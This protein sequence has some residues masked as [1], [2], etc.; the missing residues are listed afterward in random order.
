MHPL[1]KLVA[2][3]PQ[4]LADHAEAYAAL[5]SEELGTVSTALK[6]GVILGAAALVCLGVAAVLGGVALMLWAITPP[7]NLLAPWAL[8]ATPLAP[9]LLG[10]C[11]LAAARSAQ[12]HSTFD[13]LRGQ[14][15]ADMAMLREMAAA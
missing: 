2:T 14:V 7:A 4:L 12:S 9:A 1:I 11:F 10:L 3:Q 5:A 15:K 8:I 6:R 13:S